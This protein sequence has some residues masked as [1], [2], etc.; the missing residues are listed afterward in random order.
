MFEQFLV[1]PFFNLL[2]IIYNILPIQDLGVATVLFTIIVWGVLLYPLSRRMFRSQDALAKLQP[3]LKQIQ[4][5]HADSRE[6]QAKATM[7]LYR[8]RGVNP[9]GGCLIIVVQ[10][11]IF[12]AL[13]TVFRRATDPGSMSLLYSAVSRP[14]TINATFLGLLNLAQPNVLA[15]ILT[16]MAQFLQSKLTVIPPAA[17]GQ[18]DFARIMTLQA[19]YVF[20]VIIAFAA[21]QFPAGLTLYWLTSTILQ[22]LQRLW[23][24][25]Q[26][27]SP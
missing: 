10:L 19:T 9:F 22:I 16:G 21:L 20:P 12:I 17:G 13:F 8:E 1:R 7:A 23:V 25:R 4:E 3:E 14:E 24:K 11:P 5:R 18:Q 26:S 27:L 2:V 15:A 6:A